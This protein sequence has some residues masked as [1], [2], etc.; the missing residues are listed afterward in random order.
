[1]PHH[2]ARLA[3]AIAAD[4]YGDGLKLPDTELAR[5]APRKWED[6]PEYTKVERLRE[7]GADDRTVR[8]FLT[9]V[10]AMS[11]DREFAQLLD[12]ALDLFRSAPE[13]YEPSK[14]AAMPC[15]V[16]QD[17]LRVFRVSR[18][19]GPDSEAW[20]TIASSLTEPGPVTSVIDDGKGDAARLLWE[21][22]SLK[23]DSQGNGKHR[24]PLLRGDKSGPLWLGWLATLGCADLQRMDRVPVAVDTHIR[25]VSRKLGV[26]D[27]GTARPAVA[28]P[29]VR[30][31]WLA[32][33]DGVAIA[34]PGDA[35]G[36]C[37]ALNSP[38]WILGKYR[39]ADHHY[40]R[41]YQP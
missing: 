41:Q 5:G 21:L 8:L 15:D 3:E 39:C 33:V 10:A 24:F 27:A 6:T 23:R 16:L 11:R 29:A 4:F 38:L 1:M 19:H 31:A 40:R 26:V 18:K 34:G 20:A 25:K 22:D 7:S 17:Q 9:F 2:A 35:A 13:L 32:A 28:D 36:T 12:A 37:A 14:A 30:A